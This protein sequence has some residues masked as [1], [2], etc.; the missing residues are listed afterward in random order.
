MKEYS[1]TT[2]R[3]YEPDDAV[4][5]R[6]ILQGAW[7]LSHPDCTLLDVFES[8]GKLVMAFPREQHKKWIGEWISRKQDGS[9]G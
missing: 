9:N 6:N 2:Q 7:M 4:F 3:W 5:Y 8:D 1:E